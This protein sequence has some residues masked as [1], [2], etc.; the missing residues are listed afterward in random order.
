M[1]ITIKMAQKEEE[2]KKKPLMHIMLS[3]NKFDDK[4]FPFRPNKRSP[5]IDMN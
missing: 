3:E 5:F 2:S 1:K 4:V